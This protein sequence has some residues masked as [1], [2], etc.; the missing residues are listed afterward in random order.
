[1]DEVDHG[2]S[3]DFVITRSIDVGA[4]PA[5]RELAE[6]RIITVSA[7]NDIVT[8]DNLVIP[9]PALEEVAA[10]GV[11]P[12][13]PDQRVVASDEDVLPSIAKEGVPS[14]DE[15]GPVVARI[16][17]VVAAESLDH[18]VAR[19]SGDDIV[20]L[21]PHNRGNAFFDPYACDY[22][23]SGR[24]HES[25]QRNQHDDTCGASRCGLCRDWTHSLSLLP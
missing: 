13:S 6:Q 12:G 5:E 19:G 4:W 11:R 14:R 2:I 10:E 17:V 25:K 8:S 16:E 23:G 18:V 1:I 22:L 7:G 15:R 21:R 24:S 20:P 9:G 3:L